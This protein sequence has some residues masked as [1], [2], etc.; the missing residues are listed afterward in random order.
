MTSSTTP[1]A[2]SEA[3]HA[4]PPRAPIGASSEA[5]RAHYD[6]SEEFFQIV[7]G[8]QLVYSCAMFD[9]ADDLESAQLHKLDYHIEAARAAGTARVLDIGCGWGA[10]LLRLVEHAGVKRAVGL[11]LSRS[12]AAWIRRVPHAGIEV[13][14]EDWRD[15][16]PS[17]PYDAIIS[18][19]A[20]EHFVH[21]GLD[22]ARKLQA[23]REFFAF[24]EHALVSR[25]WLSLQTI[26]WA[27]PREFIVGIDS[28]FISE[29]IF[30]ESDLPLISECIRAAE[31]KF[32]L[33]LLRNDGDH[34][35]RTLRLW[36]RN[37]SARRDDAV[38]L[39]GEDKVAEFRKYL[40]EAAAGFKIGATCLLRLS[41]VKRT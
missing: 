20:F 15:H 21:P 37:L 14:E 9:A 40:R 30:R 17:R 16:R 13:R 11:T 10:L 33:R 38:A 19:G 41:F 1:D 12:Q 8:P 6:L 7:L 39:V 25:G 31:G 3:E 29:R 24:C 23:Y 18:I 2:H 5:I 26:A 22:E 27:A 36:E 34:Y 35:Y 4:R 28:K 32:E